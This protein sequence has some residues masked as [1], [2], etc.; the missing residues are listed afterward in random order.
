MAKINR[1]LQ[2]IFASSASSDQTGVIGSFAAGAP[3][4]TT[5]ISAVQ[6]L[7][8]YLGGMYSIVLGENAPC[9]QDL[10]SL[11][12][13]TT[14]Q[15]AYLMQAGVA[16]WDAETTYYI[17]SVV[18][19]GGN[20]YVSRT[21]DNL[22]NAVTT[23]ANWRAIDSEMITTTSNNQAAN[24]VRIIRVN[25][26]AGSF[27]QTLPPVAN[28]PLGARIIVK[29]ISSTEDYSVTLKGNGSENIDGANTMSLRAYE[30]V[31][32][33]NNGTYWDKI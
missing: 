23:I 22:G 30:S 29:N 24:S 4:T 5:D 16:E 28:V 25:P 20:L 8:N 13:L 7:S 15:L 18:N 17:G 1:V 2:K 31:T 12:W 9:I 21:N 14:Y 27:T 6:S 32:V 33:L 3:T 10:N 19:V 26:V 11:F